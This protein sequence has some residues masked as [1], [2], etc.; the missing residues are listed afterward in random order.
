MDI[1]WTDPGLAGL[2]PATLD[3]GDV[4]IFGVTVE[5]A[6]HLGAGLVRYA[7]SGGLPDGMVEI[8]LVDGAVSDQAGNAS[9]ARTDSFPLDTQ[10]PVGALVSPAPGTTMTSD[11]GYIDVRWSDE[12]PAGLD[13]ASVDER[14]L[15]ITGVTVERVEH[16]GGG[17]VRYW[18]G[19]DGQTLPVGEIQ[20]Q[21]VPGAVRDQAGNLSL[22]GEASFVFAGTGSISGYVYVDVNNN[23][24]KD[25][26]ELS[27]PN[28]PVTVVGTVTR[29]VVTDADGCYLFDQLPAGTYSVHALQP[30][31]FIDGADTPGSPRMG[32]VANDWF[33]EIEL[34]PNMHL[35]GYNFGELGLR[36]ELISK[37]FYLASSPPQSLE[38]ERYL[39]ITDDD[40]WFAF[41]APFDAL[42]TTE[43]AGE[44]ADVYIELYTSNMLPVKLTH[45][46]SAQTVPIFEDQQYV[47]HIGGNSSEIP[48]TIRLT[49]PGPPGAFHNA[50][51][52]L[53]VNCDQY[54]SA[55]DALIVINDLNRTGVRALLGNNDRG[56]F[57]DVSGDGFISPVDALLVINRLNNNPARKAN[58][59][60]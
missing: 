17:L 8:S 27:L 31:A 23:G 29:T 47:L 50:E 60:Q 39:T 44:P 19:D 32:L 11:P 1:Q 55:I 18:Y 37:R 56:H 45:D 46:M 25:P 6:T 49:N 28:V 20:V 13:A 33:Q 40:S 38:I 30:T 53:D 24:I 43:V 54:I 35:A 12:G 59:R 57:V 2:D 21:L 10:P 51:D 7:Y 36:A 16:L 34:E 41:Q 42:M 9:A 52:S 4:T 26:V 22:P 5:S 48:A 15:T 14:D 3:A 58:R